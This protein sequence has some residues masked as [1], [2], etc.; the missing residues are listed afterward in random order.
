VRL[1]RPAGSRRPSFLADVSANNTDTA[2]P[3]PMSSRSGMAADHSRS[4]ML[5]IANDAGWA[6]PCAAL[7]SLTRAE[8]GRRTFPRLPLMSE[9]CIRKDA[10]R[11]KG[12]NRQEAKHWPRPSEKAS[13]NNRANRGRFP[14]WPARGQ[15]AAP[16]LSLGGVR[17]SRHN[18]PVV[19]KHGIARPA[20][21]RRKTTA[22]WAIPTE[23]VG[24]ASWR[25]RPWAAHQHQ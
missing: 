17:R 6:I 23:V 15:P 12:E 20:A 7:A 9:C 13:A 4:S 3:I 11:T 22:H 19:L 5:P 14:W 16:P 25:G 21:I 18:Y 2:V 24:S 1:Y 8:L 10:E